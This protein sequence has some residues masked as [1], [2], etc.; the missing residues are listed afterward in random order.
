MVYPFRLFS[1][2]RVCFSIM[3]GLQPAKKTTL[4][5]GDNKEVFQSEYS[6][7]AILR[8]AHFQRVVNHENLSPY[9]TG[10]CNTVGYLTQ[11]KLTQTT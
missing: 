8:S 9:S 2:R 3:T 1:A 11:K 6:Q 5:F 10:N 4:N 7:H